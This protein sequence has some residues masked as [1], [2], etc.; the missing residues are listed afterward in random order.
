MG[1]LLQ[2]QEARIQQME[3]ASAAATVARE[4]EQRRLVAAFQQELGQLQAQIS[5][6]AT[7]AAAAPAAQGRVDMRPV[8]TRV[9]GKPNMFYGG[10]EKWKDWSMVLKVYM[11]AVDGG[12][13]DGFGRL[14]RDQVIPPN[15][16][17]SPRSKGLS[18]QLYY[19]LVMLSRAKA[20]DKLNVVA[21]G[22]G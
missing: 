11:M 14:E 2:A 8:D 18:L 1:A 3:A 21:Q 4:D 10:T 22:E 7:A 5:T 20:Q 16:A 6:E 12:Y 19:V 13:V 15:T 17:H 9:I